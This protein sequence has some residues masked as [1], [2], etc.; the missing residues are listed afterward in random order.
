MS[1]PNRKILALVFGLILLGGIAYLIRTKGENNPGDGGVFCTMEAK[2]CPDGSYVGRVPPSCEFSP[3]PG[4][5]TNSTWKKFIDPESGVSFDY[6]EKLTAE[7]VRTADWPPQIRILNEEFSCYPAGAENSR[8]GLTTERKVDNR[9][10]CVT[11]VTDSAAGTMYSQ[12][13][14][15]FPLG[16]RT[17]YLTFSLGF[18][19]CGNY[20]EEERAKCA[21]ER[22]TFDIDGVV[23]RIVQTIKFSSGKIQSGSGIKGTVFL[24]PVCPV[25]K[26]PPEPE[27]ADKPYPAKLIVTTEDDTEVVKEFSSGTD[28]K[29]SVSL[30]SGDYSIRSDSF[31]PP[32]PNCSASSPIKVSSGK[33]SD[34]TVYCDTGIR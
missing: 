20:D 6:P 12:Y 30:P 8:S 21:G 24:G 31:N 33:Y 5:G 3:C 25:M 15:A 1:S 14:Y 29:F 10:Y 22:E 19:N 34:T 13:A 9:T 23:D 17:A 26:D 27:C 32:F 4:T 18:P 11:R 16:T 28:G 7:Y 2:L